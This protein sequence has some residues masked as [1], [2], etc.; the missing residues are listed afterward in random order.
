LQ[1]KL[2]SFLA[3]LQFLVFYN[4]SMVASASKVFSKGVQEAHAA[5]QAVL[6]PH[7]SGDGALPSGETVRSDQARV[8]AFHTRAV[9]LR[10]AV[11]MQGIQYQHILPL[12]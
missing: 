5:R 6:G 1:I 11:T 4:H 2:T 7:R 9:L 12:S 8:A 10:L 3:R